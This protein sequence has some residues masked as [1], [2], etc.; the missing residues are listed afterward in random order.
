MRA[1]CELTVS[2]V[3][4]WGAAGL[5]LPSELI[6][7]EAIPIQGES[8]MAAAEQALQEHEGQL[9]LTLYKEG[10]VKG[11]LPGDSDNKL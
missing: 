3:P 8:A 7:D 2:S 11:R 6:R 9:T 5:A 4:G 10:D 1:D